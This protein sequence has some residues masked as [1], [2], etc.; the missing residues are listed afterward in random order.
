MTII[1]LSPTPVSNNN[2]TIPLLLLVVPIW[3]EGAF[4]NT[5]SCSA[6]S[7]MALAVDTCLDGCSSILVATMPLLFL[8][9]RRLVE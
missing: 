9:G 2:Y 8:Q 5:T 3:Q 7:F 6:L 4:C 1:L